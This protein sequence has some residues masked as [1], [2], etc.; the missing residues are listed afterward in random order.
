MMDAKLL[1]RSKFMVSHEFGTGG[2][3]AEPMVTV[4]DV[5]QPSEQDETTKDWWLLTFRESWAKPLKINRTH[6][7]AMILMFGDD[8]KNW[9]GKRIGLYKIAGTFF[10]RRQTAVR[11]K[12]SPDITETKSF[13]VR[14]FSGGKDIYNL[15]PM[16]VAAT[17]PR[18]P[19]APSRHWRSTG[20]M[21]V[22]ARKGAPISACSSVEI[23]ATIALGKDKISKA[24][25]A[26]PWVP[27]VQ[28]H[29]AELEAELAT[30]KQAVE[31]TPPVEPGA[32]PPDG[33]PVPPDG[34]PVPPDVDD[35]DEEMP[36]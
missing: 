20:K 5:R 18:P 28:Q 27:N 12:G 21:Q 1:V 30:R 8:T 14:K 17:P 7:Q 25:A 33:L 3:P 19:P 9:L 29:V 32:G 22:G 4:A 35:V 24:K 2:I 10:G 23:A 31:A 15:E 36:F 34:L 6:Q 13:S 16:S 26:E 11:I